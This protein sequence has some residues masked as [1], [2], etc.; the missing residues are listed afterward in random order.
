[1]K[2]VMRTAA[3]LVLAAVL[4]CQVSAVQTVIP[5]GYLQ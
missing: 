1:M 4:I 2:Q 3:V 5:G